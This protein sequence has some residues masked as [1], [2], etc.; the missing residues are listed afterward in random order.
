MEQRK[1]LLTLFIIAA[2]AAL[3]TAGTHW[4]ASGENTQ[5]DTVEDTRF[6]MDTTV[7][8]RVMGHDA[9]RALEKAYAEMDRVESV[10]SRHRDDS[11]I[12]R[13]NEHSGQWVEVSREAMELLQK[14]IDFGDLTDG[15]FDVTIGALVSL[16]D[17]GSGER[18]IPSH[19]EIEAA[20]ELVDYR[21]VALD[22]EANKVRI[23]E[24]AV[25]DLGGIAKGYAVDRGSAV[26]REEGI[27]HGLINAGGDVSVIGTREGPDQPWR[28]GI[29]DPAQ[30]NQVLGVAELIDTTIVTSG[31]YQRYFEKDGT[32]FH[33][34]IDP[35]TGWPADQVTSV[36][37]VAPTAVVGDALSTALFV[38][39]KAESQELLETFDDVNAIIVDKDG[40]IWVSPDLEDRFR[41]L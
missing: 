36:T 40:A 24:G 34:I 16:W 23:P 12:G 29:Q 35:E 10:F 19:E 38:K 15:S 1:L 26:L 5:Q 27:E 20:K 28:V 6:L 37:V 41:L 25:L 13:I 9:Q 33:H 17:V 30:T 7:D 11:D 39:G 21:T 22:W 18:R 32:R 3:G 8:V 2:A 31:D 14:G 4:L